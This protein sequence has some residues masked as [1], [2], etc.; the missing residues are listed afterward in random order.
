V[1]NK[2]IFLSNGTIIA[3]ASLET[4]DGVWQ[5]FTDSSSDQGVTW[6]RSESVPI[7]RSKILGE[8][9]IQPS[10]LEVAPGKLSMLTRSSTGFVLRADSE[11]NG[12]SWGDMYETALFN[13]NSGL[14][15]LRLEDGR[16]VVVHNPVNRNWVCIVLLIHLLRAAKQQHRALELLS[17]SLFQ[18]MKER[19][20]DRLWFSKRSHH[21][22]DST[23]SWLWIQ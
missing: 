1:K 6:Q 22:L 19:P 4:P 20:G 14:D 16:W 10:L 8:V 15:A 3:P 17:S 7:D 23:A 18:K 11:D 21:R 12:R 2:C 5:C 9:A 13:N